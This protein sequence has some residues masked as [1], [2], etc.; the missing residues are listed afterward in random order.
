MNTNNKKQIM[1]EFIEIANESYSCQCGGKHGS[2]I[3][4]YLID[5]ANNALPEH[6]ETFAL[7]TKYN[8]T[9]DELVEIYD[10]TDFP[11]YQQMHD[12]IIKQKEIGAAEKAEWAKE[13]ESDRN[14]RY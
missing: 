12:D 9:F 8:C 10:D 11:D 14:C 5:L 3:N 7:M 2:E 6:D 4:S 13:L 1:A